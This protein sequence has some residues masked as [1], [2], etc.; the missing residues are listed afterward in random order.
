MLPVL[1]LFRNYFEI[2]DEDSAQKARE[3][4][5]GRLVLLDPSFEEDLPPRGSPL[6]RPAERGL[7]R[8]A[9]RV[10]PGHPNAGARQ[11]PA[12]APLTLDAPLLLPADRPAA[13]RANDVDELLTVLVGT[14]ESLAAIR[15]PILD[16]TGGNPFFVEEV[17]RV[18]I[19]DG[20]LEGTPGNYRLTRPL[21]QVRV[22]PTVQAVLA[23][24][25]DALASATRTCSRR[26]LSSGGSF[27]SPSSS[28]SANVPTTTWCPRCD[29]CVRPSSSSRRPTSRSRRRGGTPAPRRSLPA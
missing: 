4:V 11:L 9:H 3:K 19:D 17:P 7:H 26:L 1:Q 27:E 5:A 24:R 22:P 16:R 15:G 13:S 28:S 14:D 12:R 29:P 21:D 18:L 2:A 8:V 23:G 6:A 20:T 25:I 10:L